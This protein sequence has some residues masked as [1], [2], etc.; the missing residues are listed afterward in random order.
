MVVLGVFAVNESNKQGENTN[1]ENDK[2]PVAVL[3]A[4]LAGK[5]LTVVSLIPK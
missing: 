5:Y 1:D 4:G 3:V 2:P